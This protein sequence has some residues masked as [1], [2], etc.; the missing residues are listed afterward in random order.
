[1]RITVLLF[2]CTLP[3]LVWGQN[4]T[5]QAT[6][7]L[8]GAKIE[9]ENRSHTALEAFDPD[10]SV[11][12][13]T[14]GVTVY[15]TSIR[16]NKTAGSTLDSDRRMTGVNSAV[17]ADGGST[18]RL[19]FG[20]VVTHSPQSDGISAIG[21]GTK[22]ILKKGTITTNRPGSAALC[23][24]N[25]ADINSEGT[26]LR[27]I[28]HQSP[29]VLANKG[30]N[31]ELNKAEGESNGQGAPIFLSDG[32]INADACRMSSAKWTIGSIENGKLKLNKSEVKSGGICG[33]LLYSNGKDN[34]VE[35]SL[36]LSLNHI[37]VKEG[38]LFFVTNNKKADI[39]VN[40]GNKIS[41]KSDDLMLVKGDDWG[42]KGANGGHA[43]LQVNGQALKG[44]VYV[45]SIS[46]LNVELNK[47][48]KLNGQINSVENRCAQVRVNIQKGA[49]WTS[50]GASYLTSIEFG[51]PLEKG[52]KQL[53]GKHTI[54]YDPSDPANAPLEGKE[55]K[56]GGGKLCPLK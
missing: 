7:F 6:W 18:I 28:D 4:K 21:E 51:Q 46:S 30:G 55:Y 15:M 31:I 23:S 45:D 43:N 42:V 54:Y 56:T 3:T 50:K 48:A 13:A 52:L 24:T 36:E 25:G 44:D 29:L 32:I 12:Y 47:G 40:K 49:T 37:S 19:E 10:A 8:D 33:F 35:N 9:S 22:C 41:Q 11:V 14:N 34:N 53:K 38:P 27:T 16:L 17:V 20:T 39:I 5:P 26:I 2:V 1:M